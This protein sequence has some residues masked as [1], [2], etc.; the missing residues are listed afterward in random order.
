MAKFPAEKISEIRDR[1]R[2]EE[3]VGRTV[4]LQKRGSRWI[5]LCPF[6]SE[7]TPSFGVSPDKQL[8]HCFGCGA[9]GDLFDYVMRLEGF[10]FPGAV[11]HLAATCGVELPKPSGH[12]A[13]QAGHEAQLYNVNALAQEA[14][15]TALRASPEALDYLTNQRGLSELIIEAFEIGWALPSWQALTHNLSKQG[16]SPKLGQELGLLGKR[17]RDEQPYD[18]LRGRITFPIRLPGG[19]IAGF[20]A[21]RADWIDK[22][23]P[24]YLNSPESPIYDK[25]KVLYGLHQA[26]DNIRKKR[27]ALLVEGYLDVIA[28]AQAGFNHAVAGCG[29]SLT[30]AHAQ[31]LARLAGEVITLYDGDAAGQKA[32][33]R[34][35]ELLLAA[36]AEVRVVGLEDGIDPDDYVQ[37]WGP[38]AL[39]EKIDTAPSAIDFFLNKARST[40]HGGGISGV[41]KAMEA[42]RPLLESIAD[43]LARD[44][45]FDAC[46]RELGLNRNT[47]N[48]HL[49]RRRHKVNQ[50]NVSL[51]SHRGSDQ[52]LTNHEPS[53]PLPHI[54]ETELLKMLLENPESV[55]TALETRSA[56]EAFAS[57]PIR[58]V[59]VAAK[60]AINSGQTFTGPE[61]LEVIRNHGL[62]HEPWLN[63]VRGYLMRA[64]EPE[65]HELE[66]LLER[67]IKIHREARLKA[68]NEQLSRCTSAEEETRILSE[69]LRVQSGGL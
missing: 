11:E 32:T 26:R 3:W 65:A 62:T 59:I 19:R 69:V 7:N 60:A 5:G 64:E 43:P 18:R 37:Q 50:Q 23:G 48:R 66:T 29:T 52:T 30:A 41:N 58:A 21:R 2:L 51:M 35:T 56:M 36:G 1:V 13:H 17:A 24:K 15:Q 46:A 33:H 20:G 12:D 38:K 57:K 40:A 39:Q 8:F 10:D 14:Y 61:A 63:E 27:Q 53:E 31:T 54:V 4:Q 9:G 49:G 45:A 55:I 42:V 16:V 6:H 67:L 28:L 68:L 34:A 44:V 25:S 22:E 47:L